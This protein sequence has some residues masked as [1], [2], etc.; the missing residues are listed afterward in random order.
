MAFCEHECM[1]LSDITEDSIGKI[2]SLVGPNGISIEEWRKDQENESLR[3]ALIALTIA[4]KRKTKLL[5]DMYHE[6][7][8]LKTQ[9]SPD[10]DR[11]FRTLM[12]VHTGV[13][14][15]ESVEILGLDKSKLDRITPKE[16]KLEYWKLAKKFHPDKIQYKSKTDQGRKKELEE[17][18]KVF[19]RILE[20]YTKL[21]DE[22]KQGKSISQIVNNTKMPNNK[23]NDEARERY[24]QQRQE[25]EERKRQEYLARQQLRRKEMLRRKE[26]EIQFAKRQ[27]ELKRR[28]EKEQQRV[29]EE[30][31]RRI[32]EKLH[33]IQAQLYAQELLRKQE[34]QK[35]NDEEMARRRQEV[36]RQEVER[37]H[38]NKKH[39]LLDRYK[40]EEKI[41]FGELNNTQLH[42]RDTIITIGAM[43]F[44]LLTKF[45]IMTL[46]LIR[47]VSIGVVR[48]IVGDKISIMISKLVNLDDM[49][50]SAFIAA[51]SSSNNKYSFYIQK[52]AD[53]FAK[54][55]SFTNICN[56][57]SFLDKDSTIRVKELVRKF[58]SEN[59]QFTSSDYRYA[60]TNASALKR[61]R[62]D[63]A[64]SSFSREIVDYEIM[65]DDFNSIIKEINEKMDM[66]KDTMFSDMRDMVSKVINK[67]NKETTLTYI[68]LL[69]GQHFPSSQSHSRLESLIS[70]ESSTHEVEIAR[71]VVH[72]IN[73][74]FKL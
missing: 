18:T 44:N 31:Q 53:N 15:Q 68:A 57:V 4:D 22:L 5:Q 54:D 51:F 72:Y 74:N 40:R 21:N 2:C 13:N 66:E 17:T 64:N 45:K 52:A 60:F 11:I 27:E 48:T 8:F 30:K 14:V 58:I 50:P 71:A 19:Q 46:R 65:L 67:A 35:Q 61:V 12:V 43:F 33:E 36:E 42:S 32:L 6:N 37:Q 47:K 10:V 7:N 38:D 29:E 59:V 56:L 62:D 63:V 73:I 1:S 69:F 24:R 49:L 20:A 25:E 16:L 41:I 70:H 55:P 9:F 34:R 26:E 23:F 3:K 28:K 39:V